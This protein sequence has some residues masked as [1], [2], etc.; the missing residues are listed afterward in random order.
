MIAFAHTMPVSV[1][2]DVS[3]HS[4]LGATRYALSPHASTEDPDRRGRVC[5]CSTGGGHTYGSVL[6]SLVRLTCY[7]SFGMAI[8]VFE[9]AGRKRFPG[10]RTWLRGRVGRKGSHI[11]GEGHQSPSVPPNAQK[12]PRRRWSRT[13]CPLTSCPLLFPALRLHGAKWAVVAAL[14]AFPC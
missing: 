12:A 1:C 11:G 10:F 4:C 2:L 8:F 6:F 5:C 9:K 3:I 13:A 14:V 7:R